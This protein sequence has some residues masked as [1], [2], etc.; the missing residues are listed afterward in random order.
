MENQYSEPDRPALDGQI[1]AYRAWATR[2]GLDQDCPPSDQMIAEL[3]ARLV[4]E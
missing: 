2:Y 3:I 4:P 1:E